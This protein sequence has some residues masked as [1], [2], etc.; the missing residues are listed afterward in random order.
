MNF[1]KGSKYDGNFVKFKKHGF[2]IMF[3]TNGDRY[4][5]NWVDDKKCGKCK[6]FKD[7]EYHMGEYINGEFIP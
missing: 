1:A 5:G 4:E 2:G 6:F 7:G 3:Y